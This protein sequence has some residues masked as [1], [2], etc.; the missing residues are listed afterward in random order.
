MN[1]DLANWSDVVSDGTVSDLERSPELRADL[2]K[3][4]VMKELV[5][6]QEESGLSKYEVGRKAGYSKALFADWKSGKSQPSLKSLFAVLSVFDLSPAEFF[7][8][9]EGPYDKSS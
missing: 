6:L 4:A 7:K 3:N 5:R 8:R 2:W 1:I 9:L